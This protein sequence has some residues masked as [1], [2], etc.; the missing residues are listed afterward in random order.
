M[1]GPATAGVREHPEDVDVF[2]FAAAAGETL[3]I[4]ATGT[5]ADAD[6]LLTV[7]DG[8]GTPLAEDDDSAGNR[9]AR[10]QLTF[11]TSGTYFARV[12]PSPGSYLV[13][14]RRLP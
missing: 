12:S 11:P 7:L 8:A 9:N 2:S 3:E 13:T 14:V 4:E 5:E 10:L 1:D 6:P